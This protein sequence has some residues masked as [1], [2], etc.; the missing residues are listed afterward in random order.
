MYLYYSYFLIGKYLEALNE[1]QK[2]KLIGV[3][4]YYEPILKYNE[5]VCKAII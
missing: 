5:I 1:I 4:S 2:Q 3:D